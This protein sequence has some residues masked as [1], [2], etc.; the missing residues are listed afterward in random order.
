MEITTQVSCRALTCNNHC[1]I[2]Y[3]CPELSNSPDKSQKRKA[4]VH[5]H[6]S[7]PRQMPKHKHQR[8][9]LNYCKSG[10]LLTKAQN[11]FTVFGPLVIELAAC[12][13][14]YVECLT[15]LLT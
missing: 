13:G 5:L 2:D 9:F 15:L 4:L 7:K 6:P 8:T 10:V 3:N 1:Y 14:V 12:L 11:S